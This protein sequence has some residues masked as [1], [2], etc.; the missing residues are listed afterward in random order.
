MRFFQS[1]TPLTLAPGEFGSIAVAY[2]FAAPVAVASFSPGG[3][4]DLTPG[5]PR[6][7][8]DMTT[9][10]TPGGVNMVDSLAGFL[11]YSDANV[12]GIAQQDEYNVVPGSLL[13][14][15][16]VAQQVFDSRFLLAFAPDAP[17]FFLVPGDNQ[18]TVLWRPSATESTGD[19]FF[20]IASSPMSVPE[21]GGAPVVN[22]LYDPE[23]SPV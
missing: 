14:K 16:K 9:L 7:F 5:D 4:T 3:A 20:E 18:V 23:L 11:G 2:I 13:G 1:S 22:N 21:G 12:D 19:P 6:V 10:T 15:A 17:E 8:T